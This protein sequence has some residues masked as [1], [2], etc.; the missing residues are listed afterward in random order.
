MDPRNK[1]LSNYNE[2]AYY[3]ILKEKLFKR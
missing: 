3:G 2:I 1:M